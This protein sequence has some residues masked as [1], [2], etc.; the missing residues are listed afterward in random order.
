MKGLNKEWTSEDKKDED[1]RGVVDSIYWD[2]MQANT[3]EN[4][5]NNYDAVKKQLDRMLDNHL[6]NRGPEEDRISQSEYRKI[7]EYLRPTKD[8]IKDILRQKAIVVSENGTKTIN[9]ERVH[10]T[11]MENYYQSQPTPAHH[12]DAEAV[13]GSQG[14]NIAPADLP[15][16]FEMTLT[17]KNGQTLTLKGKEIVDFYYELLNENLIEDFFYKKN[18]KEDAS[19]KGIF[20][21]K[22]AFRKAV[23]N[24]VRGNPKYGKDF[25]D[26]LKK[27]SDGNY[28]LSP[29]SPTMFTLMQEIVTSLFKNHITKQKINGAALIQAAGIGLDEDLRLVEDET[30]G[31]IIGAQCKMPLTSK[32]F[33][34]PFMEE[35]VINGKKVMVLDPNKLREAGLDKAV[36]YR[37][38]TENTSSMLPLIITGFT[39]QQN[40]SMIILPA[41]ITALAGSDFDVDKMFIMLSEFYLERYDRDKAW[42][43][44]G[45]IVESESEYALRRAEAFAKAL[46]DNVAADLEDE[47][48]KDYKDWK[49]KQF[50][51]WFEAHKDE[52]EYEKPVVK[53][54]EYD[55]SKSPKDNGRKA[56]NNLVIQMIFSMITE[57]KNDSL[58]NPQGFDNFKGAAKLNRILEDHVLKEKLLEN[59]ASAEAGTTETVPSAAQ[60]R[61]IFIDHYKHWPENERKKLER[62]I[63]SYPDEIIVGMYVKTLKM[64]NPE[65][66]EDVID[67]LLN[68]TTKE[69]EDFVAD[70]SAPESPIYPQTFAHSHA[71]NMAGMNQIGI[72]A[73]QGSMSAKYQR[74][75][76]Q[77]RESQQFQ[78]ERTG[79]DGKPKVV[80]IS[81]VD[82]SDGG[83][84]LKNCTEII[85]ACA[86]NGKDPNL[87]DAGSTTD[88]L[89]ILD[90]MLRC[91][92][93]HEEAVL[94]LNCPAMKLGSY[95]SSMMRELG[96][97]NSPLGVI[98][99]KML[100]QAKMNPYSVSAIDQM[101]MEAVCYRIMC[102]AEAM[103]PLAKISRADSPNGAMQNSFAKAR[104]QQYMVDLFNA[105]MGQPNFPFKRI[106]GVLDNTSID[107]S[108]GEDAVREALK[109]QPMALLHGF[110]ALGINSINELGGKQFFMLDKKFDDLVV[111]PLLYNQH[112]YTS[113]GDLEELVDNI[114]LQY[115][116]FRLSA[117]PLFGDEVNVDGTTVS[118][119]EK[120]DYY[121]N[122]FAR[123]FTTVINKYPEIRNLLGAVLQRDSNRVV[124]KDVG[125]LGKRQK[126]VVSRRFDALF[127]VGE[128]G[129]ELR[130]AG[131]DLAK[132]LLLFA[133]F[134]SGLNFG[135]DSY[136]TRLSTYFL[137]Q[138]DEYVNILRQ[139]DTPLDPEQDKEIV[140]RFHQ[141]FL[142]TN[143]KAAHF[144]LDFTADQNMVN[145]K[146]V[147]DMNDLN[148]SKDFINMIMS[149][150]PKY[151]GIQPYA[152]IR[153]KGGIWV[154]DQEK[155]NANPAVAEYTKLDEYPTSTV[156]PMYNINKSVAELSEE[157][158]TERKSNEEQASDSQQAPIDDNSYD[159]AHNSG[160]DNP[161]I[162]NVEELLNP[163]PL[164]E[165]ERVTL[166][167]GS[168]LNDSNIPNSQTPAGM[169]NANKEY[170]DQNILQDDFC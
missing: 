106:Q 19:L 145:G 4:A 164:K 6:Y 169:F 152:Y 167:Y 9:P 151:T 104:I 12:I 90:Y 119:K 58:L 44:F 158:R 49:K 140:E 45:D 159:I 131:R 62:T 126:E 72:G 102:Q 142:I 36:G 33:F 17:G 143:R 99:K 25:A 23:E 79:E 61:K 46:E 98:S 10:T 85:G 50:R 78:I 43:K 132:D 123:D 150:D 22:E 147:V 101:S 92:L 77:M 16:D 86:D 63:N 156:K 80:T 59:Y 40:G 103:E 13:F 96:Y 1:I 14:R 88:T 117:S 89:P 162:E 157:Y 108:K 52:Y 38:P 18:G 144:I 155:Y 15:D 125:S 82:V 100:A 34:E 42:E 28:V 137:T 76:V 94:I 163:A 127:T 71:R 115:I 51:I 48:G 130:K 20:E 27:D 21:S 95:S 56:R 35:R 75:K 47:Y 83:R 146:I 120:R 111:K 39:P 165:N 168:I 57:G 121:L 32:E 129:S 107:V 2:K 70:N 148:R 84:T 54:V 118:M 134:D 136:S 139:L 74:V 161:E 141:Q 68:S 113:Q 87:A 60:I 53:R 138:F 122:S 166:Y 128:E 109:K 7:M 24:I 105:K 110:Y 30:T 160:N 65:G 93:S 170:N 81:E 153:T 69:R 11:S 3:I 114:Y 116:T 26:A 154:L 55:F 64:N 135:H 8:E 41:E 31:K 133:Y 5:G 37:I 67:V 73:L 124:L 97:H 149:P 112:E 91:G 29:N 66:N